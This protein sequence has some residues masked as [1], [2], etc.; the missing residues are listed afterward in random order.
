MKKYLLF[1]LLI[2]SLYSETETIY[3]NQSAQ[4]IAPGNGGNSGCCTPSILQNFNASTMYVQSC[5]WHSVYQQCFDLKYTTIWV[6]D[7][8]SI[9]TNSN[10]LNIHFIFNQ[11]GVSN[12]YV[13]I[14]TELGSITNNL[15]SNLYSNSDWFGYLISE[16][17][18]I[19][20]TIELPIDQFL[21]NINPQ[22]IN[23]LL[24]NSGYGI[25][26]SGINA[27]SIVIEYESDYILGDV[28]N[29]MV[30]NVL[31]IIETINLILSNQYNEIVDMN[32][33]SRLDVLDI[34]Q[35]VNII[36][37]N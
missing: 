30:V 24:Y 27:P 35:L 11:N 21:F 34:V 19:E 2:S 28:N 12:S 33:D 15:A 23:I 31:D 7:M 32:Y 22:Q 18:G 1:T 6:F 20:N 37:N 36:L 10:I 16:Q 25:D 4:F 8:S 29:D 3:A 9:P 13:S 26:N 14:S 17:D 5:W